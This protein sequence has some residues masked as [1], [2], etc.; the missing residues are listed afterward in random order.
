MSKARY[1]RIDEIV[2]SVSVTHKFDKPTLK[3]LNTSD[4]E[5]GKIVNVNLLPINE[6][7]GQAKKT[8]KQDDILFSEIRPKNGRYAYI[9]FAE[10]QDFVVSTK[11]MV[12]RKVNPD[13]DNKYFYYFLTNDRMLQILQDRAENRICS[14]PQITFDLLS[15]YKVRIPDLYQQ[16]AIARV[17]SQLDEKIELNK[18]INAELE[19]IAKT[20]YDYWFLQFEFPNEDGK[21]YKSSGGKMV[22]NEKLK[23]E[24]PK[25]WKVQ[26]LLDLVKWES[27]SQPPKSEFIYN[28]EPGYIRFIQNRDYDSNN[29]ITYIPFTKNLA[30]VDEF[31]ILIDKY[32]DAGATRFGIAGAFNVALGKIHTLFPNTKE[33]IRSFLSCDSIYNFLHN[34]CMASTRASLSEK[35][36]SH[37]HIAI[38]PDW[39]LEKYEKITHDL[40]EKILLNK[41]EN[42][43]I[44]S[45][46][47][48]LLPLLMNGQ[49]AF[50]LET[51]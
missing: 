15:G 24:I 8:I 26:E 5:R 6:L 41:K 13:V 40:R 31:D 19:K 46:R 9:D 36:L 43:E 14:F 34:S 22:Q 51:E 17:L 28:Q 50:K 27:N 42:N 7:K 18:R 37:I 3:F 30:V 25:G 11:L 32:G 10:T 20:I 12:L 49:V 38:P 33:Y 29:Y 35:N 21:P 39:L 16:R 48:F 44:S 1:L 2:E 45:V 23:R 4:I 47:D